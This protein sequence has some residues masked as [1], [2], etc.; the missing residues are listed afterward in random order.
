MTVARPLESHAPTHPSRPR[1]ED[2]RRLFALALPVIFAQFGL[3][4]M[5]VVH[6]IMVGH[7]SAADLAAAALGNLYY[8]TS[9]GFGWGVLMALDPIVSQAVGAGDHEGTARGVQRGVILALIVTAVTLL[10]L[11]PARWVFVATRQPAEVVP[12]AVG[13]LQAAIP[14]LLPLS[15][16]MAFRQSLQAMRRMTPIVIAVVGAN[17]LNFLFGWALIFGAAG[18]PRMGAVGAGVAAMLARWG[19]LLLLLGFGWRSVWP[20]LRHWRR[21]SLALGPLMRMFALGAPIGVQ[22]ALEIGV[23]SVVGLM[24]GPLGT[25][26]VAGHQ[27]AINIASLSYMV[28]LG[29]AGAAAVLVGHAVGAHDPARAR[30]AAAAALLAGAGI[31][32][33][34]GLVLALAPHA[35][36]RTY[37]IDPQVV[38]VTAKLLVLAAIFQVFD[39]IQSVGIGVLRGTGDTR[40]PMVVNLVGYWVIGLPASL[41]FGF[42]LGGGAVGM[43]WG[44]VVGLAAVSAII[45]VRVVVRLRGDLARVRIDEPVAAPVPM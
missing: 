45:L 40:V 17:V 38:D 22:L 29:I 36:A 3:M 34:A 42:T 20:W 11:L 35:I 21:D 1:L 25:A 30:R 16:F 43:W 15:L 13:Y 4:G 41:L 12:L 32:S 26:T 27:V 31:M 23:F 8:M 9:S 6:T 14:G 18:F 28:P 33:L 10:F 44:L 24:M 2:F 5:S 37:T 7:V 39:A 19:L